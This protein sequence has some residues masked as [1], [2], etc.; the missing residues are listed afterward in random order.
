MPRSFRA[1]ALVVVAL[2]LGCGDPPGA[3]PAADR[4][5]TDVAA[6]GL[7]PR[8]IRLLTRREYDRTIADL[9][10]LGPGG[11]A[12][13][14]ASDAACDIREESCVAGGCQADP[15]NLVTFALDPG[16][17]TPVSVVVAGSFNGWGATE[18]A[19]GWPMVFEPSLGL[20]V[21]KRTLAE[22]THAY[23]FVLDGSTWLADPDNP[24]GEPD[25]FGGTNSI[26][27]VSACPAQP[28]A[29]SG[30]A[31][32]ADFPVEGR[33]EGYPFDNAAASGLATSVHVEQYLRAG[34]R[35]AELAAADLPALLGCSP[36]DAYDPCVAAFVDRFGRRAFRRPLDGGE[37]DRLL[38]AIEAAPAL[39]QGVRVFLRIVLSS[40]QFLYRFEIG[41]D[42]GDGTARLTAFEVASLLS[43]SFTGSTPSDALLDAAQEGA[44]D[45]PDAIAEAARGLLEDERAR[46]VARTFGAQWLGIEGA[47]ALD[48]SPSLYPELDEALAAA[49]LEETSVLVE[50][51]LSGDAPYADLYAGSRTTAAG[52]LAAL[53]GAGADGALP[54]ERRA[55]LL[56]HASVLA[57]YAHSDQ[58]SPVRRGLFVRRRLLCQDLPPPPPNAG[59]VPEVDP[60]AT[61][62]QRFEQHGSDPACFGC[63]QYIDPVGFGFE[64]FD[65]I[66]R[67]R[68]TDSGQ[69]IDA[70]GLLRGAE[71]LDSGVDLAFSSLPELGAILV[72]RQ[73]ARDCFVRQI[74][75]FTWGGLDL[76]E[77]EA[78]VRALSDAFEASGLDVPELLVSL[79]AVEA[80]S[81]RRVP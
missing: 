50:R 58:T 55:G 6:Q 79:T 26:V 53:Y 1:R 72:E 8:Q 19:G 62:R 16:A 49:M 57:T 39:E 27:S 7:G 48:K 4:D 43:Y 78:T 63:H 54:E 47:P 76:D 33:P 65:A 18:Q 40:P 28:T 13:P 21:T 37:R 71:G 61:T 35:I 59:G 66:G 5:T 68:D 3:A 52:E 41:E 17:S 67:V 12:D 30:G 31:F 23:K 46:A 75:R 60:S 32:S 11:A 14:C 2:G 56:A 45:T 9:F 24:D 44:L 38:G 42:Q 74:V 22:G 69:P 36:A 10:T 73:S 15:C 51:V 80:F 34:A 81:K 25:G 64:R 29:P 70:S 20:W 77:D